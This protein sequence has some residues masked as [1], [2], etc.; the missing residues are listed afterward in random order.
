MGASLLAVAK[1][2]Y[3]T[4]IYEPSKCYENFVLDFPHST[5]TRL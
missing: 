5:F 1:Y 2:L 3:I 4:E